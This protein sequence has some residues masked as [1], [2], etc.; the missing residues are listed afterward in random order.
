M[1]EKFEINS[2]I[3]VTVRNAADKQLD[4]IDKHKIYL[5]LEQVLNGMGEISLS[6]PLTDDDYKI[7][8]RFHF[9]E[10]I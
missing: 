1:V 6:E 5:L 9:K 8:T 7:Y 2:K 4:R 10:V 3:I